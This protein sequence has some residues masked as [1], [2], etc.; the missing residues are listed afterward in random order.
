[1]LSDDIGE[2][3]CIET[4]W[5]FNIIDY[6]NRIRNLSSWLWVR[7]W[8]CWT[9]DPN[10]ESLW[11]E[12]C[13][14]VAGA[15]GVRC[16][17]VTPNSVRQGFVWECELGSLVLVLDPVNSQQPCLLG[18]NP[19]VWERCIVWLPSPK[20]GTEPCNLEPIS[21]L[22]CKSGQMESIV[23]CI[24]RTTNNIIEDSATTYGEV[25]RTWCLLIEFHTIKY[26]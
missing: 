11:V 14:M 5:F 6:W 1:M 3:F 2:D 12:H 16:S 7:S 9:L 17:G 8:N 21:L 24:S 15:A 19:W 25:P 22:G 23:V 4:W 13:D 26:R 10:T 20:S 18:F